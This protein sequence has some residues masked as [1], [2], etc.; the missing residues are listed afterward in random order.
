MTEKILSEKNI[1]NEKYDI[2]ND[3][4]DTFVFDLNIF[5]S[6][7]ELKKDFRVPG[8]FRYW[9]NIEN[10]KLGLT[11][12]FLSLGSSKAGLP[13]HT[14]GS[15]WLGLVYGMK[16]WF[17][18]PPGASPPP[19]IE[20]THNP[21]RTMLSWF[22][23][24]YPKLIDLEYPPIHGNLPV[25]QGLDYEGY[26]PLECVQRAGD[27]MYVPA[28]W[29]HGTINIGDAVGIGG[30]GSWGPHKLSSSI[31]AISSSPYHF[32]A[33][34]NAAQSLV[35]LGM[36]EESRILKQI[37]S[38]KMG[39][40]QLELENFESLVLQGEDTWMVQFYLH[41]HTYKDNAM[42]WDK[43]AGELVGVVSVGAFDMGIDRGVASARHSN[44]INTQNIKLEKFG[45]TTETLRFRPI[46]RVYPGG[47]MNDSDTNVDQFSTSNHR[48]FVD[49]P[50]YEY[51]GAVDVGEIVSYT[52][53]ITG[54]GLSEDQVGIDNTLL[55]RG[56]ATAVGVKARRYFREAEQ[57]LRR[58]LSIQPSHVEATGLL[59]EV[60]G[61][62]SKKEEQ[63]VLINDATSLYDGLNLTGISNYSVA[64]FY[65]RLALIIL[66]TNDVL[67]AI[68]I[69]QKCLKIFPSFVPALAGLASI[70]YMM[71]D[72][73]KTE[74]SLADLFSVSPNH[75]VYNSLRNQGELGG[76]H[77]RKLKRNGKRRGFDF[78]KK[79]NNFLEFI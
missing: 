70:Y 9:D 38:T 47:R 43:V 35:E 61:L 2:I 59:V 46:I 58:G 24:I 10:N 78:Q 13:F 36:K 63:R 41:S 40:I 34:K 55:E 28:G 64:V 4:D 60:L 65:Y 75:A 12:H 14:H 54:R 51:K 66:N 19:H 15:T 33:L 1:Y 30:H 67:Q 31:E 23:E 21:V 50:F 32:E 39:M 69:L 17:I 52:R 8:M 72:S 76:D 74:K 27:V 6:I 5:K 29:S 56:S 77:V 7:P 25:E 73:E 26:R 68:S 22:L 49:R 57:Y 53:S 18:Y 11:R 45:I 44:D 16:R 71:E 37:K 62:Q 48:S 3:F 20:R 42:L 79:N